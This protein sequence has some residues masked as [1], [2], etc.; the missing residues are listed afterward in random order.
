MSVKIG[1]A[2]I[3][4][5]GTTTGGKAGDQTT[6]E[7]STQEWYLHSKKWYVIRPKDSKV[8]ERLAYCMQELCDNNHIGYSQSNRYTA[9][10]LAQKV[11]YD[12]SK[13]QVDCETDCSMAVRLCLWFAGVKVQDFTTQSELEIL[14]K[15]G[16]FDILREDKYCNSSSYLKKGDIL[17]TRTKG[18]T[19]IVLSDGDKA[20]KYS[21]KTWYRDSIGWWYAKNENEYAKNEWLKIKGCKYYFNS[22]GYAVTGYQKI[23]GKEYFFNPTVNAEKECALMVTNERGELKVFYC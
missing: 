22:K 10:Q 14:N 15:T 17:V 21:P 18:H 11:G 19:A 1:S 23:S 4:E 7:C 16:G 3:N 12:T 20:N 8:A 6:Y 13:I 9:F 2:R 5:K